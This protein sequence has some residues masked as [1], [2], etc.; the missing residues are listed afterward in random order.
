MFSV[1][2]C[3][4]GLNGWVFNYVCM[5]LCSVAAAAVVVNGGRVGAEY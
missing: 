4:K 5:Y 3:G 2:T 1:Y